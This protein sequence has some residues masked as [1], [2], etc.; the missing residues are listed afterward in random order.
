MR[1]KVGAEFV[2]GHA[3]NARCAFVAPDLCQGPFEVLGVE[4][5]AHQG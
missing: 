5:L 4:H 3:V 1:L 2:D